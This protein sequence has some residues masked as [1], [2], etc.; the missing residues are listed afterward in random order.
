MRRYLLPT[1]HRHLTLGLLFM[2]LSASSAMADL[3]VSPIR[4]VLDERQRSAEV[5]LI[6]ITDIERSYQLVWQQTRQ[7]EQGGYISVDPEAEGL[8]PAS[9]AIRFSPRQV[10]IPPQ[11]RQR[12]RLRLDGNASMEAGEY[13][14]HLLF[15]QLTP[16]KP[17]LHNTP[18]GQH[19]N[20]QLQLQLQAN[21]SVA[22]PVIVRMGRGSEVSSLITAMDIQSKTVEGIPR[23]VMVLDLSHQ[24]KLSSYG[25]VTVHLKDDRQ[26]ERQVGIMKNVALFRELEQRHLTIPLTIDALP[27]GAT[28]RINY[29]GDDEFKGLLWDEALFRYTP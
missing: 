11:G 17:T 7:T 24:G 15:R 6:N 3:L 21:V 16:N 20:Q 4:V 12:V 10:T 29:S 18:Q 14:S 13:R 23:T 1:Q 26:P 2:A 5:M 27:N 25:T 8:F 19:P 28:I 22:I 9:S